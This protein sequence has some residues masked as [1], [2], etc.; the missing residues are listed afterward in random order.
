MEGVNS[1]MTYYKNLCK[2]HNVPPN[3]TVRKIKKKIIQP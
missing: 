2:C 3:A 1:T